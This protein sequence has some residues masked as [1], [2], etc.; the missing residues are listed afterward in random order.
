MKLLSELV[1]I[2]TQIPES[3]LLPDPASVSVDSNGNPVIFKA[4]SE[5]LDEHTLLYL[6]FDS[7]AADQS[8]YKCSV[9]ALEDGMLFIDPNHKKFGEASLGM[10]GDSSSSTA[11]KLIATLNA[12][13]ANSDFTIHGWIRV[14]DEYY[15]RALFTFQETGNN[16]KY[17]SG[18]YSSN[19]FSVVFWGATRILLVH[20]SG[21]GDANLNYA[22]ADIQN[23]NLNEWVHVAFTRSVNTFF[24]F[25]NG[26]LTITKS[27][28][29]SLPEYI[30]IGNYGGSESAIHNINGNIDEFIILNYA[31]WTEDFDVPTQPASTLVK[32][33][34][35]SD[36]TPVTS[37]SPRLLP[38][39]PANGDIPY[40]D[41]DVV[42]GSNDET[43]KFLLQPVISNKELVDS[44]YGN[45]TKVVINNHGLTVDGNGAV[46]FTTSTYGTIAAGTLP[47]DVLVHDKP[48]VIDLLMKLDEGQWSGSEL[49]YL[50]SEGSVSFWFQWTD[51]YKFECNYDG[52]WTGTELGNLGEEH[53]V[54]LEY[55]Q[56]TDSNWYVALYLD[57]TFR[58]KKQVS[59]S[60]DMRNHDLCI[61]RRSSGKSPCSGQFKAIRIRAGAPY[62]GQT[63]TPDEFPYQEPQTVG[64]WGKIN[65]SALVK[66]VNGVTPDE[67]GN[68]NIDS[69][70]TLDQ[71]EYG[72]V[73]YKY[74]GMTID[75]SS[76]DSNMTSRFYGKAVST[77]GDLDNTDTFPYFPFEPHL[78]DKSIVGGVESNRYYELW[79]SD[80]VNTDEWNTIEFKSVNA[81]SKVI[82][83]K[84]QTA[85]TED[86]I[87]SY[88]L[89]GLNSDG[90]FRSRIASGQITLSA[91]SAADVLGD[92]STI[93]F[94]ENEVAEQHFESFE[95][96]VRTEGA[97][98]D[99]GASGIASIKFRITEKQAA[100]AGIDKNSLVR[101]INGYKPIGLGGAVT[102]P[103]ATTSAAGLMAAAD[104]A[105]IA[106]LTARGIYPSA[107]AKSGAIDFNEVIDHGFYF[108]G[109]DTP[110][111]NYPETYQQSGGTL[112]VIRNGNYLTQTLL[113]VDVNKAFIRTCLNAQSDSSER[114]F[115]A[116]QRLL[117]DADQYSQNVVTVVDF[118][119]YK[120]P[121][122]YFLTLAAHLN[123]PYVPN[124]TSGWLVVEADSNGEYIKQTHYA[125]NPRKIW[126]RTYNNNNSTWVAWHQQLSTADITESKASPGYFKLPGGTIVQWGIYPVTSNPQTQVI[127][128]PVAL[129]T[130]YTRQASCSNTDLKVAI[131]GVENGKITCVSNGSD[132]GDINWLVIGR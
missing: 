1:T 63:F 114:T 4:I 111:L 117:T 45:P 93:S 126:I 71:I 84:A 17:E 47:A 127:T 15:Q 23:V 109:G 128:L 20:F 43:V 79:K 36:K 11:K 70:L 13:L 83:I 97:S 35:V 119:D 86:C 116:W 54:T 67:N 121:G 31:K 50:G 100:W 48:W 51:N 124:T 59:S 103:E 65:K 132:K 3:R 40:F 55:Y 72:D 38:E 74:Q 95:L 57:G 102:L 125:F 105:A 112:Q 66:S 30:A 122:N 130:I 115:S 28:T 14:T 92:F 107:L 118:N 64:E 7:N 108:I 110:H 19:C 61:G 21:N 44:A 8:S 62:K 49:V 41:A 75:S 5:G 88:I 26:K 22:G 113:L 77:N 78:V 27:A 99:K 98:G 96:K 123:S 12:P 80:S 69:A 25:V 56:D 9:S 76:E 89:D 58:S 52:N 91:S 94:N 18:D 82:F 129:S 53:L 29:E 46:V 10:S 120:A 2:I 131:Y 87:V 24:V 37:D 33:Y 81:P 34:G 85:G 73:P 6:P 39:N 16:G 101:S 32:S 42:V 90:V 60:T 106:G 104:K 68:V